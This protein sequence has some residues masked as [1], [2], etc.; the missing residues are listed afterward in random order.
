M[1]KSLRNV[2]N[3]KCTLKDL[4]YYVGETVSEDGGSVRVALHPARLDACGSIR[5]HCSQDSAMFCE[6]RM[7]QKLGPHMVQNLSSAS[8]ALRRDSR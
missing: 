7:A 8:G 4:V 2:K 6:M 5:I 1:T 3:V